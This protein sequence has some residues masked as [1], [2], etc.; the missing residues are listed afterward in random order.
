MAE[1]V[2]PDPFDPPCH[3]LNICTWSKLDAPLKEYEYQIAKDETCIRTTP[4]TSM[5]LTW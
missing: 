5:R 1:Q 2:R 4:L 3:T